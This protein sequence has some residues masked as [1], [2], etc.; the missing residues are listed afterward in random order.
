M[1]PQLINIETR[2]YS[3]HAAEE[4]EQTTTT[5]KLGKVL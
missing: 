4:D 5:E 2:Y 1:T 3:D